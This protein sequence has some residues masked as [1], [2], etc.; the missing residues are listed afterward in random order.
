VKKNVKLLL[1]AQVL[2]FALPAAAG[3]KRSISVKHNGGDSVGSRFVYALR[4]EIAK[5]ARYSILSVDKLQLPPD[6]NVIEVE[7]VSVDADDSHPAVS[8]AIS[9]LITLTVERPAEQRKTCGDEVDLNLYHGVY[10]VGADKAD[11][12]AKDFMAQIDKT[13]HPQ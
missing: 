1:A 12:A 3:E 10:L 4:E 9:T 2:L 13:M 7:I 5:S 6:A 11:Q 8:S